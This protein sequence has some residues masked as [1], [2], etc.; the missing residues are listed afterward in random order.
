MLSRLD[1]ANLALGK[2]GVSLTIT[3]YA[4][5]ISNQA[6]VI[7]RHFK[8]AL[9]LLL[10]KHPWNFA[11]KYGALTLVSEDAKQPYR[12]LYSVPAD[13]LIIREIA[14]EERFTDVERYEDYKIRWEQVYEAAGAIRIRT[15]LV[16]AWAKYTVAVDETYSFPSHFGRALAA[17][18][19]LE[20]APS[21]ITNNFPKIKATLASEVM[22]E[23]NE[24]IADDMGRQP[25]RL[26]SYSPFV[27]ARH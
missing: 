13:C 3:D 20:I 15:N 16:D 2:L 19:A 10:E 12:Y 6:K 25:R 7:R 4:N 27:L 14:D 18:L 26:E 5:D 22:S 23:V 17:Q 21:L 24:G 9:E 11:T 8:M 1:I